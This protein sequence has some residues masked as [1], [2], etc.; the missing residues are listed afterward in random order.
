MF[1]K[2]LDD[3]QAGDN[4]GVLLRGVD[5]EDVER[6]QVICAPKS[7]TPHTKFKGQVYVLSKEEGGDIRRF[8][9]DID[10]SFTSELQM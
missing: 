4:V 8:S 2:F 5:K 3:A 6:G 9:M 1:R 10:H 7:I